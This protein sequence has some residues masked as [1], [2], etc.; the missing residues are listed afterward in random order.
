MRS[1][2]RL[3]ESSSHLHSS[4][5]VSRC[6]STWSTVSP[7]GIC[8]LTCRTLEHLNQEKLLRNLATLEG[9]AS[10][11]LRH[12]EASLEVHGHTTYPEEGRADE[13]LAA[14]FKL[15]ATEDCNAVMDLSLIH[16]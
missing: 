3:S 7:H 10:I 6:R 13:D 15:R 8:G 14:L 5:N 11:M 2:I 4:V 16:I 12:P 9:I 1:L